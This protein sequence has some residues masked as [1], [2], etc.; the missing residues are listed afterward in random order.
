MTFSTGYLLLAC[1]GFFSAACYGLVIDKK[2]GSSKKLEYK[3][4]V[5][6]VAPPQ[7]TATTGRRGGF[8]SQD[9][10]TGPLP[11]KVELRTKIVYDRALLD[12]FKDD[13]NRVKDWLDGVVDKSREFLRHDSLKIKVDLIVE[14]G[15]HFEDRIIKA[16]ES[17]LNEVDYLNRQFGVLVSVFGLGSGWPSRGRAHDL[18]LACDTQGF[19]ISITE[20]YP[21]SNSEYYTAGIFVHELGHT[22]GMEHDF[23]EK[24][25]FTDCNGKGLMSYND[26]PDEWSDCS[27]KDFVERFRSYL[28]QCLIGSDAGTEKTLVDGGWSPWGR[29]SYGCT[30]QYVLAQR[31]SKTRTCTNP[32][33]ANGGARCVGISKQVC[34]MDDCAN[35]GCYNHFD[36]LY[37]NDG[38]RLPNPPS[39]DW[40][41]CECCGNKVKCSSTDNI[42]DS[43]WTGR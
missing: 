1:I 5:V 41:P 22:L 20:L 36:G 33:P 9:N 14:E 25:R 13:H 23:D 34:T 8:W 18:G 40:Y 16:T 6:R 3:D 37:Y 29:C 24:H 39:L 15:Y 11:E 26:H 21:G 27:N 42:C 35:S 7:A 31:S 19:G 17:D 28:H 32:R 30:R 4:D 2:S 12:Y 38:E 10:Y 43:I